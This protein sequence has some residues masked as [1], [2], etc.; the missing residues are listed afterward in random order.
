MKDTRA[1]FPAV[2]PHNGVVQMLT[3]LQGDVRRMLLA[4]RVLQEKDMQGPE[5]NFTGTLNTRI[6]PHK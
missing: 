1:S 4:G 3:D 6:L 2:T 5:K